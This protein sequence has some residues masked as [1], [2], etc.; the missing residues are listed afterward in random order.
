MDWE[1]LDD[2]INKLDHLI[3]QAGA[4][5]M[6]EY[7]WKLVFEKCEEVQ[8]GFNSKPRYPNKA[9][10]EVA[11]AKFNELR[12]KAFN[13][14]R[15]H[16]KFESNEI[17]KE[18]IHDL[19]LADH[20]LEDIIA[21]NTF[22][23][24]AKADVDDMKKK[25]ELL[26]SIRQ[27]LRE[28]NKVL[29]HEH[30]QEIWNRILEAQAN[31]DAWWGKWKE[32]K[33]QRDEERQ[34]K[35]QRHNE[36]KQRKEAWQERVKENISKNRVKLEKAEAHAEELREKIEAAWNEEFKERAEGWL[37]E[38]E[39]HIERIKGWIEEDEKKLED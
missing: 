30:H 38:A 4:P 37:E 5:F 6:E 34:A 24:F 15:E 20:N 36:W 29:I 28:N 3:D 18:L 22:L 10:R 26:R 35:I 31:Q 19:R 39:E 13:L 17:Y 21:E 7:H 8:Q 2:A 16:R 11:W 33:A 14:N 27:R 25:G 1:S 12:S 9:Q 32:R 23:F